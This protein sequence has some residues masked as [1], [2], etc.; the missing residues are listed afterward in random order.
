M[1]DGYRSVT[2]ESYA[3][4]REAVIGKGFNVDGTAGAQCWD[5]VALFYYNAFNVRG[6]PRTAGS[7]GISTDHGVHTCWDVEQCREANTLSGLHQ[8]TKLENVGRG[9]I[10]VLDDSAISSTG[11]IAFADEDYSGDK[12]LRLLGQN[13]V[14]PSATSGHATTATVLDCSKFL[15]A[16][17]YDK[18]YGSHPEP[19]PVQETKRHHYPWA[20]F[21]NEARNKMWY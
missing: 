6:Y 14:D 8:I 11:H 15:G 10:I 16:W 17:R 9:D 5:L 19:T 12:K 1:Y 7:M 13:Q 20:I 21:G 3:D 4:W 18:W 2:V